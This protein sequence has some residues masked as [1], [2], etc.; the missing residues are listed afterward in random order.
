MIKIFY[1]Y[2]SNGLFTRPT[3]CQESPEE[4]GSYISPVLC[5]D[6]EPEFI[7]GTWPVFDEVWSNFK[8][9]R[10]E[11]WNK[12][13]GEIE[14]VTELGELPSHLVKIKPPSDGY[15]FIDGQWEKTV[16]QAIKDKLEELRQFYATYSQ[17]PVILEGNVFQAD[18]ASQ[19]FLARYISLLGTSVLPPGFYW[20][21]LANKKVSLT[22]AKFRISFKYNKFF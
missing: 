9:Y 1:M 18:Y 20:L 21:S 12:R 3:Y 7:P 13:T 15:I 14:Q 17:M 5:T 6:I 2:D 10:G 8:D 22:K 11:A 4:P 16:E 19:D